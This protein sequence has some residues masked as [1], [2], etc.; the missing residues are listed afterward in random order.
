MQLLIGYMISKA[1]IKCEQKKVCEKSWRK[2]SLNISCLR[3]FNKKMEWESE[4]KWKISV[5]LLG[6][7]AYNSSPQG[8]DKK[9]IVKRLV[10]P[11]GAIFWNCECNILTNKCG[12]NKLNLSWCFIWIL[13][14]KR[15]H[16]NKPALSMR[17][18]FGGCLGDR[19]RWR[20]WQAAKSYG[21]VPITFDP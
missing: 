19:R 13:F 15:H 10:A 7:F 17:R 2:I 20:T 4:K 12:F 8:D 5:D 1:W 3:C 11:K 16:S 21:E 14:C 9:L 18:A 6:L